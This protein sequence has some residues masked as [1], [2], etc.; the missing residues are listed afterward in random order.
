MI[1]NLPKQYRSDPW[2]MALSSVIQNTIN[3]QEAMAVS[4]T[5]QESLDTVTWNIAVEE[6]LAGITPDV[7][8]SLE[9]RRKILKSKWLA[10]GKLTIYQLSALAESW[11]CGTPEI[12][13]QNGRIHL[14]IVGFRVNN[15]DISNLRKSVREIVPA[16]LAFYFTFALQN[17]KCSLYIGFAVRIGRHLTVGCEIPAELDVTY[18]TDEDGYIL[19]D[20][21][22]ARIIDD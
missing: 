8:A 13:F 18:L 17:K 11:E 15:L 4:V 7:G 10:G 19:T 21:N 20:E 9:I 3:A 12:T 2:I 1:N 6:R 14:K 22:G 16:H 5:K